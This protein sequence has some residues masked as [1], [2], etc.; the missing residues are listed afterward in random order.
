[1]ISG[2]SFQANGANAQF[3]VRRLQANGQGTLTMR[4]NPNDSIVIPPAPSSS[5]VR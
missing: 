4:P 2:G 5:L 3:I 1:V